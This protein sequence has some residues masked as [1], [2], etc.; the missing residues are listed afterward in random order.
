[1]LCVLVHQSNEELPSVP[2]SLSSSRTVSMSDL[3]TGVLLNI[4]L[5]YLLMAYQLGF[6]TVFPVTNIYL[7]SQV[8]PFN[9]K[10]WL[11]VVPFNI[12]L[13]LLLKAYL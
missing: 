8:L 4:C 1:M 7:F 6:L 11:L 10:L 2:V 13:D 5:V 9:V 3:G 12:Q